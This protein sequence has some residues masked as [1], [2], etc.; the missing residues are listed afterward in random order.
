MAHGA[1]FWTLSIPRQAYVSGLDR[2]IE[3]NVNTMCKVSA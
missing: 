2:P 1:A 3:V